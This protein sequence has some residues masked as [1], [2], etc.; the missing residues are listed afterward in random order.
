MHNFNSKK[1]RTVGK[2]TPK[3]II[4]YTQTSTDK[5]ANSTYK[6]I[7]VIINSKCFE[8]WSN[9]KILNN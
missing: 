8:I 2:K 3:N 4:F 9:F 6:Q 5:Q 7:V 1:V